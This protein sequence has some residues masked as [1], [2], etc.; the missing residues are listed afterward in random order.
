M[1]KSTFTC[2]AALA[3]T[4]PAIAERKLTRAELPKPVI[5]TVDREAKGAIILGYSTEREHGKVVYEAE[6]Q[7]DGHI[8]DLQIAADGTLNEIEEQ[9]DLTTLPGNVQRALQS[10]AGNARITKVESLT[11]QGKL[12]A[13]EAATQ[14][15]TK[16]GEVQVGPDGASLAH[17]E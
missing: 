14:L 1:R 8:R 9:V 11:K 7:I 12:V 10:R 3:L 4:L 2:L 16:K 13:Y 5:A 17:P 15:G 6:T